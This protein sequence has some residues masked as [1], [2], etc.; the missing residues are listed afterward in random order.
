MAIDPTMPSAIAISGQDLVVV[1]GGGVRGL[2]DDQ[3]GSAAWTRNRA[4]QR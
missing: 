4:A 3:R 2:A 1:V